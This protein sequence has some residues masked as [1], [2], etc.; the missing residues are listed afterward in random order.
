MQRHQPGSWQVLPSFGPR[1]GCRGQV[2]S[3]PTGADEGSQCG[4]WDGRDWLGHV[5]ETEISI[6]H[7]I[8]LAPEC[9]H[10]ICAQVDTQSF[11]TF[12]KLCL[13]HSL[14][15]AGI[16]GENLLKALIPLN[17]ALCQKP[18]FST[19][20]LLLLSVFMESVLKGTFSPSTY[21]SSCASSGGRNFWDKHLQSP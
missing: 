9:F 3:H 2:L 5:Q 1:E 11:N 16:L 6:F 14:Q 8:S 17:P 13:C 20:F 21:S 10:G 4:Q 15:V 12:L 18:L 19:E 7:G